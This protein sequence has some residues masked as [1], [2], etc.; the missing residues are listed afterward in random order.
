MNI[1]LSRIPSGDRL[2]ARR[3][4]AGRVGG[5]VANRGQNGEREKSGKE[6]ALTCE[7]NSTHRPRRHGAGLAG[8]DEHVTEL[9]HYGPHTQTLPTRRGERTR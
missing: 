4:D 9:G 7:Q 2:Y 8:L 3:R 1:W 5:S 6:A